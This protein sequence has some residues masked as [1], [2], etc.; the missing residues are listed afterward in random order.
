MKA[1]PGPPAPSIGGSGR[2][3]PCPSGPSGDWG[4][5][6]FPVFF[7]AVALFVCWLTGHLLFGVIVITSLLGAFALAIYRATASGPEWPVGEPFQPPTPPSATAY[8]TSVTVS[9]LPTD[10]EVVV[11]PRAIG[12]GPATPAFSFAPG[13]AWVR[14]EA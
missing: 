8:V 10:P 7:V 5:L 12:A 13:Q 6:A 2:V 1:L 9:D 11:E 4:G 3:G 14:D